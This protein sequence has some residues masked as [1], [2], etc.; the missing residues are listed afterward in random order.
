[1][2]E[3]VGVSTIHIRGL[4]NNIKRATMAVTIAGDSMPLLSTIIFK[5]KHNVRIAQTE[6]ATYPASHH[7]CCQDA[8]RMDKQ[9]K[10]AWVEEVLAPLIATAHKEIIP[11]LI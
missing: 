3:M 6:F 8:V 1:M 10:L 9:V 7:Y 2:L 11:L 5:W 4:S